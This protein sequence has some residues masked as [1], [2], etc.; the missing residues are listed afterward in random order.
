MV[1]Q[2]AV[3]ALEDSLRHPVV[4]IQA[5][6]KV[7]T[8][9]LHGGAA[10]VENRFGR[11]GTS[12]HLLLFKELNRQKRNMLQRLYLFRIY[13]QVL[14]VIFVDWVVLR[15]ETEQRQSRRRKIEWLRLRQ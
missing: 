8:A 15:L 2:W 11:K 12:Y 4:Q 9:R 6:D 13:V 1:L 3:K 5:G 10:A 14:Q 7:A